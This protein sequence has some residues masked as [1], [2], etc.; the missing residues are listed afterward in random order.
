MRMLCLCVFRCHVKTKGGLH[1]AKTVPND[2][3][4]LHRETRLVLKNAVGIFITTTQ[5]GFVAEQKSISC[6]C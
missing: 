1:L 6:S 3:P 5:A 2:R 4:I